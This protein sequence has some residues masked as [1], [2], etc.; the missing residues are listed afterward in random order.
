MH[1]PSAPYSMDSYVP[2]SQHLMKRRMSDTGTFTVTPL[3]DRFPIITPPLGKEK[4]F[5]I[6]PQVEIPIHGKVGH[7]I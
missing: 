5:E 1:T 2:G 3:L 7:G 4:G 6:S